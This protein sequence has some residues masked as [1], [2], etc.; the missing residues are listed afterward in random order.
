MRKKRLQKKEVKM[1]AVK[2]VLSALATTTLVTVLTINFNACSEQSPI[3]PNQM[4]DN[5]VDS[6]AKKGGKGKGR[7]G[8]S[9]NEENK[10]NFPISV[11]KVF[12]FHN[13]E[14]EYRGGDIEFRDGN[15]SK[16]QLEDGALTPPPDI[17]WGKPVTITMEVDYNK[18]KNEL[19]YTFGP[20]GCKFNPQAQVKLDYRTLGVDIP[21]LYYIDDNG[22]YIKQTPEN[23]EINKKWLFIRV[24]HFSRYAVAWS[25]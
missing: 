23:I 21:V 2:R 19:I 12:R 4:L 7:P 22:N 14:D 11:S 8:K 10:L 9:N 3:S 17:A 25:N 16:F 15:K 20:H 24:D 6:L 13:G 1:K 18:D 5:T